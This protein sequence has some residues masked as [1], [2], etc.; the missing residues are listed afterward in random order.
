[1]KAGQ[2]YYIMALQKEANNKD[3]LAV[4]WLIPGGEQSVID[5]AYLSPF[6]GGGE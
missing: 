5:G 2:R 4:A 1:M 6:E 3:N